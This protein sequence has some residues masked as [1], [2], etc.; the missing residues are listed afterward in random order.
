MN[1][2]PVGDVASIITPVFPTQEAPPAWCR[3]EIL[4]VIR[5]FAVFGI[6]LMNVQGFSMISAAYMNPTAY[7]DLT[8]WNR[9]VWF[10]THVLADQKFFTLFSLLF[11]ASILLFAQKVQN[12]GLPSASLHYRRMLWLLVIG[13]VHAYFFWHGDVL[14]TYA[15]AGSVAYLF[16]NLKPSWLVL[17][18]AAAL[19]IPWILF[20]LAGLSM[21]FWP[22]EALAE[23]QKEWAP[24]TSIINPETAAFRGSFIEQ[25]AFR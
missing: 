24:D 19:I 18:G 1:P 4:D 23:V 6:L 20:L 16:R 14:V 10:V 5:G 7:G 13:L 8:G 3:I 17:C 11:G 12:M 15:I 22:A 21:P 2:G 9:W 25:F